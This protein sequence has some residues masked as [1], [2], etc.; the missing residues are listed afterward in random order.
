MGQQ[1]DLVFE[2]GTG[3]MP[4]A[5]VMPQ[6][7]A[8]DLHIGDLSPMG[9]SEVSNGSEIPAPHR[10]RRTVRVEFSEDMGEVL[11]PTEAEQM[12]AIVGYGSAVAAGS[13]TRLL[14]QTV[15]PVLLLA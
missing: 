15:S 9:I 2:M 6:V 1:Y 5:L 12:S 11:F 3:I 13:R 10:V 7:T 14:E 4:A 8:V